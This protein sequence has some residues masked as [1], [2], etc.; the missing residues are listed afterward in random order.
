MSN[1]PLVSIIINCYNSDLYLKETIDSVISQTYENWEI[2]FWDNQS[3]DS[4]AEIVKSYSDNRIKYFYS[5]KHTTLGEGRNLALK[6]IKGEFFK[7]LDADDIIYPDHLSKLIPLFDNDNVGIIY[8]NAHIFY[9]EKNVYK[10]N[11]KYIRPSGFIFH[12][13]INEYNVLLPSVIVRTSCL[14]CL[15]EWFDNRFSMV[16]EF[17]F[18]LR[19]A[20]TYN[21]NYSSD[22][23][24]FWRKYPESL[25]FKKGDKWAEEFELLISKLSDHYL[26]EP[27]LD[28][29]LSLKQ[30]LAYLRFVNSLISENYIDRSLLRPFIFKSNKMLG[31][32]LFSFLGKKFTK[33]V[34]LVCRKLV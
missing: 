20:S 2:I 21:V 33:Q 11:D 14:N 22:V 16:E 17:D 18:L 26:D 13:W 34:L 25:S 8:S 23:L 24:S 3:T 31:V 29:L 15:N 27:N 5:S 32:Y 28:V 4:S 10:I 30:R 19:I 1:K 9:Q 7:F 6:M 12:S